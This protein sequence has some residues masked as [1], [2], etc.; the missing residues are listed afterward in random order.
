MTL[1]IRDAQWT[2]SSISTKGTTPRFIIVKWL[3]DKAEDKI[4]RATRE[5]GHIFWG[6]QED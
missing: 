5:K 3:K 1:N 6:Q 2:S 4:L